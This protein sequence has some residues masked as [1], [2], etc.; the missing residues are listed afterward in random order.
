MSFINIGGLGSP[1]QEQSIEGSKIASQQQ[2]R[3][4][5]Q[6]YDQEIENNKLLSEDRQQQLK[7]RVRQFVEPMSQ[8]VFRLSAER[9]LQKHGLKK[10]YDAIK[11]GD[12]KKLV[13][14]LAD[15]VKK[16]GTDFIN[17]K[18]DAFMKAKGFS[19]E[20]IAGIKDGFKTGNF[21]E[22]AQGKLSSLFSDSEN[23]SQL[24][25]I[26]T[27]GKNVG[28]SAEDIKNLPESLV[29]NVKKIP[30]TVNNGLENASNNLANGIASQKPLA[31]PEV[32]INTENIG[33]HVS[34]LGGGNNISQ[35]QE[36]LAKEAQER[37]T[38]LAPPVEETR[39]FSGEAEE[40]LF[41]L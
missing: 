15:D 11:S 2:Q 22:S 17:G 34:Q 26:V 18:A 8:E 31:V 37:M 21:S 29:N 40:G 41:E 20:D 39:P 33:Q 3:T 38:A 14:T 10:Y 12:S 13:N 28:L 9:L 24:K 27:A 4:A 16:R 36:Q 30:E 1:Q 6:T 7:E 32:D 35:L 23:I 5:L 19:N 25:D